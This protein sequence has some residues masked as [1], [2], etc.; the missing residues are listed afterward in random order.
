LAQ[1]GARVVGFD[2]SGEMLQ[3]AA[4]RAREAGADVHWGRADAHQL[5]IGDRCVDSAVCL[6][7]LMHAIDW[8]ACI[9]E[10][11]RVTRW[12][13]VVDFPAIGS[14]AAI[15]SG[16]R[17]LRHRRGATVEAYRVLAERDVA[18][19]FARHGF[20]IVVVRRQFVLPIA[21]HKAVGQFA[22]TGG[23][24]RVFAAIGLLKLL[25]SPVTMVAE[26]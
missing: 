16:L 4:S 24:E 17:H 18:A 10:L 12:R 7:L 9:G 2:Y 1:R 13:V 19:E 8:R 21:L 20:R 25:G 6:R 26:R 5:P 15:E 3:V 23:L 11:C 14:F 22:I